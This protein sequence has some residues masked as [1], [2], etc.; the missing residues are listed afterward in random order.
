MKFLIDAPQIT[1]KTHL[2]TLLHAQLKLT[3]AHAYVVHAYIRAT[4]GMIDT[5]IK[6]TFVLN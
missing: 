4:A 1:T 3:H 6:A 5:V 2:L